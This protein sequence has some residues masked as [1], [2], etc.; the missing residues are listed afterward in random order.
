M[1]H[2]C[3]VLIALLLAGHSANAF[4]RPFPE[5]AQRATM[6][7]LST[8]PIIQLNK[9]KRTLSVGARI[10]NQQNMIEMPSYIQGTSFTV[11]YTE[12][13]NGDIDRVWILTP[14]EAKKSLPQ[15]RPPH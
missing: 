12:D 10:W 9:K 6:S 3:L 4:E 15:S 7:S 2:Q 11:N 13:M 14:Q 1:H 8:Y 5:T